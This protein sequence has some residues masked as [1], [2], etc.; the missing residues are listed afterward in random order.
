MDLTMVKQEQG[1]TLQ[2]YMHCFFDKRAT[3]VDITDKQVN[4][5]FQ[6]GLYHHR[7]FKDFG[8]HHPSSITK[9]KDMITSW[10]DEEDK[11][12]AKYDFVPS[13]S[14]TTRVA[15]T[16]TRIKGVATT[17][18]TTTTRVLTTS[19]SQ[20]TLSRPYSPAK[21][22]SKKTSG[23]FRDLLKEKCHWHQD[24][25]HTTD[26]CYQLRRALKDI[27]EPW[28]PHNKKGKKK[29]NEG[30]GDFQ[31]PDKIVNVLFG[32][33]PTKRAQKLTL[34][35]VLSIEP[36]VTTPLRWSEIPITFSC[37]DQWTNFS[38]PGRFPLILNLVVAGSRLTKVLID[39]VSGLDV[40][41]TK[42]L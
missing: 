18:T 15:T 4:E 16:I 25:N 34:R 6:D 42:T 23:G 33:L 27:P 40:L 22:N 20:T 24:G 35:E 21:D 9:L 10:V 30:N 19:A 38:E 14:K 5:C 26:Q 8:R 39:S 1:E 41:F 36:V 3:I 2:Q 17:T 12:N 37:A 31:E 13:K 28:H 11:A 32:G 29:V 7:T